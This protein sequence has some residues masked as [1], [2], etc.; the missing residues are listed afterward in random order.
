MQFNWL[1]AVQTAFLLS[2]YLHFRFG[3]EGGKGGRGKISSSIREEHPF[4]PL[5]PPVSWNAAFF[6]SFVP[7]LPTRRLLQKKRRRIKTKK[8]TENE[9]R[10]RRIL[11]RRNTKKVP[12]HRRRRWLPYYTGFLMWPGDQT[13]WK[14]RGPPPSAR[15][16]RVFGAE[17]GSDQ[18]V[19]SIEGHIR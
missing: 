18:L 5:L 9:L 2:K 12:L 19:G 10:R 6:F 11:T 4:I 16:V 7:Q 14:V 15:V 13:N 17:R 3:I 8:G 1:G